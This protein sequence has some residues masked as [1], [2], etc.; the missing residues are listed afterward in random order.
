M[1]KKIFF[2]LTVFFVSILGGILGAIF[3]E[4]FLRA[5]L[6]KWGIL[7][8]RSEPPV[9]IQQITKEIKIQENTALKEAVEKVEKTLVAI[10]TQNP[11]GKIIEGSGIILTSDGLVL[12]LADLVPQGGKF[13]IFLNGEKSK[14]QIL[15]RDLKE[16]LALIKIEKT[17]LLTIPFGNFEKLKI[18]ERVFLVG[19]HFKE[20]EFGKEVNE[21]IIKRFTRE[22]IETNI[23]EKEKLS[24]SGLFDIEGNLVGINKVTSDGK[25]IAVPVTKIRE[26]ANL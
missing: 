25:I 19:T 17:N 23:L 11:K 26:F 5:Y 14:F 16:N 2:I 24:G 13:E 22:V 12:T 9:Y 1:G 20:N 4:Q 10:K 8:I 18:G 3:N 7:K 15:K 21:G 6:I